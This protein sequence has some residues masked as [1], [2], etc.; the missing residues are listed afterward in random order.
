MHEWG[1]QIE[2]KFW[3]FQSIN[4]EF[5]QKTNLINEINNLRLKL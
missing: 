5:E 2:N 1:Y 3:Y 4:K